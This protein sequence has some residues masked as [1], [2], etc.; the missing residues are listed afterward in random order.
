M[1]SSLAGAVKITP[2]HD[3][4]DYEIG[5]RHELPFITMMSEDGL[6]KE[7]QDFKTDYQKF[8]VS[9]IM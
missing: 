3:H 1:L 7:L 4:N 5:K 8:S 2:G 9:I 6:I